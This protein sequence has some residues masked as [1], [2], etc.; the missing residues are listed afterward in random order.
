MAPATQQGE[1]R[2]NYQA[3]TEDSIK[4]RQN[5]GLNFF[6]YITKH[7]LYRIFNE[8]LCKICLDELFM[9]LRLYE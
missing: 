4:G 7:L 6:F 1:T 9:G 8:I 3:I 2:T 5:D